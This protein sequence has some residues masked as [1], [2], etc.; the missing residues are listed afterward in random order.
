[1]RIDRII[2]LGL[3]IGFVGF[4]LLTTGGSERYKDN[5]CPHGQRLRLI[6]C[7]W[8]VRVGRTRFVHRTPRA[9]CLY[10]RHRHRV[11]NIFV[12]MG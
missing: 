8:T 11:T 5:T 4:Y 3:L 6:G 7:Y 2:T 12:T 1:M 9:Q 10:A